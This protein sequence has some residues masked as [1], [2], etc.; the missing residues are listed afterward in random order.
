LQR[1]NHDFGFRR[2]AG[3]RSALR[4]RPA[5]LH[6][7]LAAASLCLPGRPVFAA[8]EA[9]ASEP[10]SESGLSMEGSLTAVGQQVGA[11]AGSEGVRQRRANL[12]GDLQGMLPVIG[13]A[14][15]SGSLVAHLRFGLGTGVST[16][17]IYSA[18]VNSTGF[19]SEDA[20]DHYGILAEAYYRHVHRLGPAADNSPGSRLDFVI[21]KL[22]PFSFFD[23]NA[24]ASEETEAFLN[25]AF[26]HNPMLD[27]GGDIGADDFGFAPGM[28]AAWF[29]DSGSRHGWGLSLGLLGAGEEATTRRLPRKPLLILQGE[30]ATR[31]SDGQT[32][33]TLRVYAWRNRLAEDF[34]GRP[35]THEGWGLSADHRLSRAVTLFGRYGE[36]T[37]G[38]GLFD[39]A[40]TGL[41]ISGEGW[42]RAD[43]LLGIAL[44]SL[45]TGRAYRAASANGSLGGP[46]ASGQERLLEIFY[47]FALGKRVEITPDLQYIHRPAGNSAAPA[48]RVIGARVRFGF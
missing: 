15:Q 17:P 31:Q 11:S 7:L 44:G 21:G 48:I 28:R 26:V 46:A 12:R 36:R 4:W 20:D 14:R 47:R 10:A 22:D 40:L 19:D 25:N 9:A 5:L 30:V 37:R 29:N 2:I 43:D 18:T 16:R 3:C 8:Q 24:L 38:A 34:D 27:A 35:A 39:R 45:S 23:R 1:K 6:A 13:T 41:G 42:G 32:A 33:G